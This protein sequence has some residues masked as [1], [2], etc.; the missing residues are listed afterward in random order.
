MKSEWNAEIELTFIRSG[1]LVAA[2]SNTCLLLD[3]LFELGE[4]R[5]ILG[6]FTSLSHIRF[7]PSW[8]SASVHY[9][10][11]TEIFNERTT[12]SVL[13]GMRGG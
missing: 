11:H 6:G 13:S 2:A 3:N 7:I 12:R 5:V 1:R 4:V 9:L 10:Q 8:S